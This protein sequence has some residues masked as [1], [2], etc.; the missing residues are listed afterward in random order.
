[1][2]RPRAQS[3]F[4]LDASP[5][6]LLSKAMAGCTGRTRDRTKCSAE[7][8]SAV[9]WKTWPH[10][11]YNARE[12]HSSTGNNVYSFWPR[13]GINLQC[14][15]AE[16]DCMQNSLFCCSGIRPDV[17][18]P[19]VSA[20]FRRR[21]C[22]RRP[23]WRRRSRRR[24]R[25]SLHPRRRRRRPRARPSLHHHHSRPPESPASAKTKW[26]NFM[27]ICHLWMDTERRD[28]Q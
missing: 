17:G 6:A 8:P 4:T 28:R 26:R 5:C 1:M 2:Q 13:H 25:C 22:S 12:V 9:D 7:G 3:P 23:R 27:W 16:D 18:A 21:C 10:A 14:V 24:R 15:G 11:L 19:W 20:C